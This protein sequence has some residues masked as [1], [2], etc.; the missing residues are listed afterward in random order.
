MRSVYALPRQL[1][2]LGIEIS[3]AQLGRIVRG[4]SSHFN[5]AI[6]GGLQAVLDCGL[7]ELI[8]LLETAENKKPGALARSE[9]GMT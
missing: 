9:L 4:R 2:A 6:V 3:N 7:S 8:A 5:S 1:T